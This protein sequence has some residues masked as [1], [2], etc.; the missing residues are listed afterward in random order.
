MKRGLSQQYEQ[1]GESET[2][3]R[4]EDTFGWRGLKSL[5][6]GGGIGLMAC[7]LEAVKLV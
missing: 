2:G 6:S 4:G 1:L 5:S 7:G 3:V